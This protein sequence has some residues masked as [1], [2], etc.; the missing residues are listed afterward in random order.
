MWF[1]LAHGLAWE[2]SDISVIR[3][4]GARVV[5][6]VTAVVSH[7]NGRG[8]DWLPDIPDDSSKRGQAVAK[9]SFLISSSF[10]QNRVAN[11]RNERWT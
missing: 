4:R 7:W 1:I 8:R 3:G 10:L 9:R 6:A 11:L 2:V 5:C